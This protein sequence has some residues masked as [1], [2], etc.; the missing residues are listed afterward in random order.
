MQSF[1]LILFSQMAAGLEPNFWLVQVALRASTFSSW[2]IVGVLGMLA[3]RDRQSRIDVLWLLL[4]AGL[5]GCLSHWIANWLNTPRPFML[6]L[7]LDYAMH[8]GRGGMPSTHASVMFA[9]ASYLL[10]RRRHAAGA[11]VA[12]LALATG[13]A[14]IYLGIH[15][16]LDVLGGAVLGSTFGIT[17]AF[18]GSFLL[19]RSAHLR[20]D[21]AR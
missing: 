5:A 19:S 3:M 6:G 11:V 13:V 1:N 17:S 10:Y 20:S 21:A 14:R 8:S 18:V 2:A 4:V 16:P 15:F 7:S 12:A 9:V